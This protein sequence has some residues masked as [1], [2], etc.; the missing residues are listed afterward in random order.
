MW[1]DGRLLNTR[2]LVDAVGT[3][4]IVIHLNEHPPPHFHVTG[5]G[6][7]ASFAIDDCALLRADIGSRERQLVEYWQAVA[8]YAPRERMEQDPPLRLSRGTDRATLQ[9]R[10]R[11]HTWK[12]SVRLAEPCLGNRFPAPSPCL[13]KSPPEQVVRQTGRRASGGEIDTSA[14]GKAP[15][16]APR[17]PFA[18]PPQCLQKAGRFRG[19]RENSRGFGCRRRKSWLSA[20]WTRNARLLCVC[21][22]H[23]YSQTR[24]IPGAVFFE[25]VST[26]NPAKRHELLFHPAIAQISMTAV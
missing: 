4:R 25:Y 16:T 2:A 3:L 12:A 24:Q 23:E 9:D 1:T 13:Q 26:A 14:I 8:A 18:V 20:V 7:N 17:T 21:D 22:A 10:Y 5:N 15:G 19:L 11:I 6:I